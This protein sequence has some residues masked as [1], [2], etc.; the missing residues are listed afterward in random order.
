MKNRIPVSPEERGALLDALR[1]AKKATSAHAYVRGSTR[2]FYGWLASSRGQ[3][4]PGAPS[5]WISGDCHVGNLGLVADSAGAIAI[6]MRDLDQTVIGSPAHD[7]VRLA[8]SMA[9]AARASSLP[10]AAT[11]RLVEGLARGYEVVL[12]AAAAWRPFTPGRP[13][14]QIQALMHEAAGRTRKH[15]LAERLGKGSEAIPMGRRF[16]PLTGE[17]RAA[18]E[19]LVASGEVTGR[20]LG[21][22]DDDAT[23][24]VVDAAYW[25][26]G[27]S[28]LGL[29]RVAALVR[30][31]EGRGRPSLALLD[32]KEGRQA[33]APHTVGA[34]MPAHQ[35]ERIVDGAR[36]LSPALGER[37]A[38]ATALGRSLFVRELLPQDLK[39][40]LQTLG[41]A[42]AI[43]TAHYLATIVALAHARQLTP[44]EC[45]A[46]LGDFRRG[47]A[48]NL[49]A[50]AWLWA[51]VVDLVALHE[52]AYLEHCREHALDGN[53]APLV[54]ADEVV[55]HH[56]TGD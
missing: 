7:V 19:R 8:L 4:L 48:R 21:L 26:K 12:E 36:A 14:A 39:F 13:P 23:V 2:R 1:E 33:L 44:D 11:A 28:S 9:M 6:E 29:W 27:C 56:V 24:E 53:N 49:H 30:L 25:V 17:E 16:W 38:P 41:E 5:L 10:G 40:E 22:P 55:S 15:L 31:G 43:E 46:W 32:I 47:N 45:G 20:A 3:S 34:P 37:M 51:A 35:G 52:G 18:V 42:E 50:P 54:D